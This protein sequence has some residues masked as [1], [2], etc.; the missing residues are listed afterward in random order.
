MLDLYSSV[1]IYIYVKCETFYAPGIFNIGF[2]IVLLKTQYSSI[3]VLMISV[4]YIQKHY[5]VFNAL[6]IHQYYALDRHT[7][8]IVFLTLQF[9]FYFQTRNPEIEKEEEKT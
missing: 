4:L 1:Y 3:S 6:C 9:L 7:I 8:I 5:N 2:Y